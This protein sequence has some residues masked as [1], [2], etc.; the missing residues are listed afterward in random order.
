M[1]CTQVLQKDYNVKK[2]QDPALAYHRLQV[3]EIDE[4]LGNLE[5]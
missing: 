4:T 5:K 1:N 3:R 2:V